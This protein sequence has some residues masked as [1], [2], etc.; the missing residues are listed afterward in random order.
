MDGNSKMTKSVSSIDC[1]SPRE[2][3]DL[4]AFARALIAIAL[5]LAQEQQTQQ[6]VIQSG[7]PK[8]AA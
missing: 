6:K 7:H 2:Q 4:R 8:R 1:Y 3:G 5:R